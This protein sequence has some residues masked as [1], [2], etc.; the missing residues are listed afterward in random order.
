[1]KKFLCTLAIVAVVTVPVFV[2]GQTVTPMPTGGGGE[3][4]ITFVPFGGPISETLVCACSGTSLITIYDFLTKRPVAL[5]YQTGASRLNAWFNLWTSQV[6]TLGGYEPGA[7]IC[8][9]YSGTSCT[10]VPSD[11]LI[12]P[13]PL[14]G[15]GTGAEPY[16]GPQGAPISG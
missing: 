3:T 13:Y 5:V 10:E 12:T 6:M 11:G 9:V 15:I 16:T 1:M 14:P 2:F 7:G 4:E 8:E